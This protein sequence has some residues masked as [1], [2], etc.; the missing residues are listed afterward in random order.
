MIWTL[1]ANYRYEY[2]IDTTDRELGDFMPITLL[3]RKE[4]KRPGILLRFRPPNPNEGSIRVYPGKLKLVLSLFWYFIPF[5]SSLHHYMMFLTWCISSCCLI[6]W[7]NSVNDTYQIIPVTND[8]SVEDVMVIALNR[9]GLDA[10]DINRYRLVEVS[11]EKGGQYIQ[12][13]LIDTTSLLHFN[14]QLSQVTTDADSMA[15]FFS[16]VSPRVF[17]SFHSTTT[18]SFIPL[19]FFSSGWL[20]CSGSWEDYG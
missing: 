1:D 11:L 15:I 6:F 12:S 17:Y 5:I 14:L 7:F 19:F 13:L 3:T 8:T 4:G 2:T 16:C 20:C 18:L 10:R 9:F